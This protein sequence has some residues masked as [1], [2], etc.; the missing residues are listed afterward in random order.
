VLIATMLAAS[1]RSV[2]ASCV[3]VN[4]PSQKA[5]APAHCANRLCCETSQQRT[6]APIQP[7]ATS[8][9]DQG[10][11]VALTALSATG[12]FQLPAATEI[13]DF[14]LA[15]GFRHSPET[16]AFLCIRLI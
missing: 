10:N 3:L 6:G 9:S 7:P 4:A 13:S 1:V 11:F 14:S 2:P 12:D 5:C 15:G 8:S 16:L